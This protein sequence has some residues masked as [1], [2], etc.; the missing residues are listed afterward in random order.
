MSPSAGFP[1]GRSTPSGGHH[2]AGRPASGQGAGAPG[3]RSAKR[4]PGDPSS[5]SGHHPSARQLAPDR[6]PEPKPPSVAC[7]RRARS[8]R[9]SARGPRA[10]PRRRRPRRSRPPA[11]AHS[12]R[13]RTRP[14]AG[15]WR[16]AL[17]RRM[18][19]IWATPPGS[20][21]AHAASPSTSS[22]GRCRPARTSSSATTE[23]STLAELDQ[24]ARSGTPASIR[25]RSSSSA[26]S[27]ES[28]SPGPRAAAGVRALR[29]VGGSASRS[30][31]RMSS[32][33]LQRGQRRAQLVRRGRDERAPRLLL[34]A[35]ALLHR[36]ERAAE[37]A[38][39][40]AAASGLTRRPGRCRPR[41][42]RGVA[43]PAQAADEAAGEQQAEE[44]RASSPAAPRRRR[45]A[46]PHRSRAGRR[47][48]ACARRRSPACSRSDG[49]GDLG[50][51]ARPRR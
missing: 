33:T 9:R 34:L 3:S 17:S 14:P 43:Q 19:T 41:A 1:R 35:Q 26:A 11:G 47:R 16:S 10:P 25:L 2:G 50:L 31:T 37:V 48:A 22:C 40:V 7:A 8:A 6:Q 15:V 23:R 18:R 45:R 24:L 29:D 12:A 4:A 42:Q 21:T 30:P 46:G 36:R 20:P 51:G 44:Q 39:L 13:T 28:R 27:R 49:N 32:M 5:R 38:D